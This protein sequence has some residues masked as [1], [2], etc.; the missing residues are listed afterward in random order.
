M[1]AAGARKSS[2]RSSQLIAAPN[3][4]SYS[5]ARSR[6]RHHAL[7]NTLIPNEDSL[8]FEFTDDNLFSLNRFPGIDRLEGG[9]RANVGCTPPGFSPTASRSTG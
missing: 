5:L 4:S 8:D 9:P 1:P 7:V 2:N 6:E 3:G